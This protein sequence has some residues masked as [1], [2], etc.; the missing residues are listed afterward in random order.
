MDTTADTIA[1]L[2]MDAHLDPMNADKWRN[3]ESAYRRGSREAAAA[4]AC[5]QQARRGVNPLSDNGQ[6]AVADALTE[7]DHQAVIVRMG[8]PAPTDRRWWRYIAAG[9]VARTAV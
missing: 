3:L 8:T 4:W 2:H 9:V 1:A 7:W 6:A 5:Y